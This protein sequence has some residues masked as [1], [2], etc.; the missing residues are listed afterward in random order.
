MHPSRLLTTRILLFFFLGQKVQPG[1]ER[2]G[3]ESGISSFDV[4]WASRFGRRRQSRRQAERR[5]TRA[6]ELTA[7]PVD[8]TGGERPSRAGRMAERWHRRRGNR[9]SFGFG[10]TAGL[11][12]WA[13]GL[14]AG[15][16]ES[17]RPD[18][19]MVPSERLDGRTK[20][21]QLPPIQ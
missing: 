3:W 1:P 6:A 7:M 13:G 5:E 9:S 10:L 12:H 2:G 11:R 15:T 16:G 8:S 17:A 18:P 19:W 21:M 4:S 14:V 20:G